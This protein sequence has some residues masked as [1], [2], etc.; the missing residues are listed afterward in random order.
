MAPVPPAGALVATVGDLNAAVTLLTE[1]LEE[2][3]RLFEAELQKVSQKQTD[4]AEK[5]DE[6]LKSITE[7]TDKQGVEIEELKRTRVL[8]SQ[9]TQQITN[10][11]MKLQ[12]DYGALEQLIKKCREDCAREMNSSVQQITTKVEAAEASI[13]EARQAADTI[14][15]EMLPELR[16]QLEEERT[17]RRDNIRRLEKDDAAIKEQFEQRC[18]EIVA[19]LRKEYAEAIA[20]LLADGATKEQIENMLR[21]LA[22]IRTTITTGFAN[23]DDSIDGLKEE[24]KAHRANSAAS[25]DKHTQQISILTK[26]SGENKSDLQQLTDRKSVV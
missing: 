26:E 21:E 20:K 12:T 9:F 25:F 6:S 24:L 15:S 10:I 7:V 23:A 8:N 11:E 14:T 4:Y 3:K 1:K 16:K 22:S 19:L 13:T 2:Q 18:E 17:K 5:T